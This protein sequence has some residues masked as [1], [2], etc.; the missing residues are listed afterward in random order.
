MEEEF[1]LK[2]FLY[3]FVW[4]LVIGFIAYMGTIIEADIAE[5]ARQSFN[6]FPRVLFV[7]LFPVIL[8]FLMRLPKFLLERK[9]HRPAGFDWFKFLAVGVPSLYVVAMTFLP[10]TSLG[11]PI[12]FFMLTSETS[13]TA[14]ATTAGI[15]FGYVFL[16]SFHKTEAA[17]RKD[18][19]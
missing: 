12:P 16:D 11:V 5:T 8:G 4:T 19:S 6:P 3:Y 18:V 7:A 10:F 17:D 2:R 9:E 15:V 13:L 14:I 1:D